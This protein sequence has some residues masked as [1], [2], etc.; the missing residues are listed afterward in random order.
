MKRFIKGPVFPIAVVIVMAA[1]TTVLFGGCS[2][3]SSPQSKA[4]SEVSTKAKDRTPYIP[5]NDVEFDN[6]NAAQKLYDSPDTIIWCSVMPQASSAPILTV[7][8]TGK[9]TSSSTT[10]FNPEEE[11]GPRESRITLPA[12][13][14]DGLYHPNPPQYRYGFTPG[15]QYVDFFNM[16]TFCTTKPLDFQKDSVAVSVDGNL[17][18]A[19]TKAEAALKSG[20]QAAAQAILEAAANE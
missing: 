3:E 8:I 11:S 12:R 9:L 2:E 1:F 13:S 14:V 16:P 20:D 17:T 7:P 19:T 5:Q 6:Y 15:G 18:A 4:K 10:Y